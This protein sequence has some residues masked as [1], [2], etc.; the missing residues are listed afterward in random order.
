MS[1][2]TPGPWTV[3]HVAGQNFAIQQFRI[4]G[5]LGDSPNVYPIFSKDRSA[6][7]GADVFCSPENARLIAAA[8][9][10]LEACIAFLASDAADHNLIVG[11]DEA[12]SA[13]N[14]AGVARIQMRAAI[15]KATA[16]TTDAGV[17]G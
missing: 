14:A 9:E 4:R 6:L 1:K 11:R 13:L 17:V 5:M 16:S 2:Y 7:D 3:T 12:G 10:L 8:P 15:A